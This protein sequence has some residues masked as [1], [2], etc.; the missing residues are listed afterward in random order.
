MKIGFIG[1]GKMATAL[2]KGVLKSGLSQ[3]SDITASDVH[4]PS[5]DALAK[6]TGVKAV[7]TNVEV[8]DASD[9]IVLAVKPGDAD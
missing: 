5:A 9:A 1:C 7:A 8:V 2:I 6:E 3:P 4:T